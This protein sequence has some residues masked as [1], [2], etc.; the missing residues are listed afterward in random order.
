MLAFTSKGICAVIIAFIALES[1]TAQC[2]SGDQ[3][4]CVNYTF[5][6]P[7]GLHTCLTEVWNLCDPQGSNAETPAKEL[8]VCLEKSGGMS[9]LL[10][11]LLKGFHDFVTFLSHRILG[12]TLI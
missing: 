7:L 1:S 5:P 4:N 6:D 11:L 3:G 10:F 9:R 12:P 2:A 8:A